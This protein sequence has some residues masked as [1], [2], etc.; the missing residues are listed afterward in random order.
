MSNEQQHRLG[1]ILW[2]IADDFRDYMLSFLFLRYL[3]DN[4]EES[5]K[6]ELGA[7]YPSQNEEDV[8]PF[9]DMMRKKIHY[10]IEPKYLWSSISELA[11]KQ[12]NELLTT[13]EDGFKYIE[14]ESFSTQEK[15][16]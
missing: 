3:S 15:Q 5:V 10:V 9:E 6:K 8:K 7:D 1:K 11:R 4:Y 2:T 14:N 13:L 16:A 12:S